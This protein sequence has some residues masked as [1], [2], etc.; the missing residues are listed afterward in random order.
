MYLGPEQLNTNQSS[1]DVLPDKSVA[2]VFLYQKRESLH[3]WIDPVDATVHAARRG[4][5]TLKKSRA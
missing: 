4:N 3:R 2:G 1:E 5:L